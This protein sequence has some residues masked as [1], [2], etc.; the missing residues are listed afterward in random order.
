MR[1]DR[2]R[3]RAQQSADRRLGIAFD[4]HLEN[5][6]FVGRQRLD[7]LDD[8]LAPCLV[9]RCHSLELGGIESTAVSP[10]CLARKQGDVSEAHQSVA[11]GCIGRRGGDPGAYG[12]ADV[13][14][15][16]RDE[17][18]HRSH[19]A[20]GD[21]RRLRAISQA[22]EYQPGLIAIDPGQGVRL[23]NRSREPFGHDVQNRVAH[24]VAV[25]CIHAAHS[26]DVDGDQGNRSPTAL[27][28]RDRTDEPVTK[29]DARRH[30]GQRVVAG[31]GVDG[32]DAS[33]DAARRD[34]RMAQQDLDAIVA[35][36][37]AA[38]TRHARA[39]NGSVDAQ[40]IH[41]NVIDRS[42]GS[43]AC[44]DGLEIDELID[45][46]RQQLARSRRAD[47]D[48]GCV[49]DETNQCIGTDDDRLVT[50]A[51]EVEIA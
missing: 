31:R 32:L 26:I 43:A 48:D 42:V 21:D 4:Q 8:L 24:V 17:L 5:F 36:E 50:G 40:Y 25:L 37:P 39:D 6:T 20:I 11:V 45:A 51:C 9:A 33:L 14:I 47:R 2:P 12:E 44:A 15:A 1:V 16:D 3:A 29:L 23:A 46:P 30:L 19:D 35:I 27:R 38:H 34:D 13:R 22:L 10:G 49:V 7:A 41:F 18:A 28:T